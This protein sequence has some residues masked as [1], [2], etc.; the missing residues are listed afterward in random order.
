MSRKCHVCLKKKTDVPHLFGLPQNLDFRRVWLEWIAHETKCDVNK[1]PTRVLL[2]SEHFRQEDVGSRKLRTGS[3]PRSKTDMPIISIPT[4]NIA[5]SNTNLPNTAI[6]S[7][8]RNNNK[9]RT[10]E[11][12]ETS[13]EQDFQ[14]KI[15]D[16]VP[17][18][19]INVPN[20]SP[21]V[22]HRNNDESRNV[23]VSVTL[24]EPDLQTPSNISCDTGG[25]YLLGIEC[26]SIVEIQV[27]YGGSKRDPTVSGSVAENTPL[28]TVDNICNKSNQSIA[29]IAHHDHSDENLSSVNE[30]ISSI[31]EIQMP[32][33]ID[34][35]N[36]VDSVM[37]FDQEKE[38]RANVPIKSKHTAT[39]KRK[40]CAANNCP[41]S[42]SN[43][44]FTFPSV[45]V[46]NLIH[47]KNLERCKTWVQN[48]GNLSLIQIETE[49][50]HGKYF[51]C[52]EHYDD[53][54]F[55]NSDRKTLLPNA[56]PTLFECVPLNDELMNKF[57]ILTISDTA[58]RAHLFSPDVNIEIEGRPN[59]NNNINYGLDSLQMQ[60]EN[61][62][63]SLEWTTCE[64]CKEKFSKPLTSN[65]KCLHS[66]N[67]C[68]MYSKDNDM[69][70]H[71][72][73]EVL[74]C[75]SYIEEQLIARVH[76]LISVFKLS[77]HH[78]FGYRG[79]IINFPQDIKG[80][81]KIL[82][83]NI[84]EL[85]SIITVR[86]RD[87]LKPIDFHVRAKCV[88]DALLYLKENNPYYHDIELSEEN[89]AKLPE[90]GN[91][92]DQ[93]T[94]VVNVDPGDEDVCEDIELTDEDTVNFVIETCVPS[95]P[96]P[97]STDKA[98]TIFKW[99]TMS[100]KPINEFVT[101][102][103]IAMA[104]PKLSPTGKAD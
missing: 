18:P 69:D 67:N 82:P 71:E 61:Y 80:F 57:P 52:S 29:S 95:V 5:G 10:L 31:V 56:I 84:A 87:E 37:L 65:A 58:M 85:P 97:S 6:N 54:Q 14:G 66:K 63:H 91:T 8:H 42:A 68:S 40:K 25:D 16:S 2:C 102:G 49:K 59:M 39:S 92:Y 98:E 104:F 32:T 9:S 74:Q 62:M 75:L 41:G 79:N 83:H 99:P 70:P 12:R 1:I 93:I 77:G 17:G 3:V 24:D 81:A 38:S 86:T 15:T 103:Y 96:N 22:C 48:C 28:M 20:V 13:H 4:S 73:P 78:Q 72:V 47:Y 101:P 46:S 60:F 89:L 43:R 51:L 23:E 34:L 26:S 44:Y 11:K 33:L 35:T 27:P 88:R 94:Q 53:N 55:Y 30:P 45:I 64:N 90:D 21:N 76:P 100:K 19:N 7:S 36:H 50:L